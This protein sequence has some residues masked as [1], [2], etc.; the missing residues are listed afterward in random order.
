[1][2]RKIVVGLS[3][4]DRISYPIF[5]GR[6]LYNDF[7][8]WLLQLASVSQV[9]II[10]D[11]TVKDLFASGLAVRLKDNGYKVLLLSI[12]PGEESK[13]AATKEYLELEMLK[14]K[15]DRHMLL[16]AIGGGVVGDLAGFVAATY[17]RGIRYV[18]MPTT[19][20]SML[21]SSVGGKTAINTPYGKNLIGAFWQ[22][23]AVIM[24]LD[25]LTSLPKQH[26]V[27]GLVE[28]LKIFISSDVECFNFACNNIQNILNGELQH[29]QHLIEKAVQLKADIVAAD[30][31]E[32]NLRMILNFGHTIGHAIEK[33]SNFQIL[34][35]Y[36]VGLG[37]LVEAKISQL[38][39]ILSESNY[40]L[41]EALFM[42]IGIS[43]E[44]LK[45]FDINDLIFAACSDKKNQG[46]KVY[47]ILLEDIAKVYT[48]ETKVA[49]EI[50][51]DEIR[52]AWGSFT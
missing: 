36:A 32:E 46:D 33:I 3:K 27:N 17:M 50:S 48:V 28:A 10:T 20:L 44:V 9:V 49:T 40:L 13:V 25:T 5:L 31:R 24:D 19:L 52:F 8:A 35:G 45:S 15:C 21:D 11:D 37:I 7:Q 34:H 43:T 42:K 39:G 4:P 1:M 47:C 29:L 30:E 38:R 2:L 22:P 23:R 41:I 14:A 6:A 16:L 18:Q 26:L 12:K 51:L